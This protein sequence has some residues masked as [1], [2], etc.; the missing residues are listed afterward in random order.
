MKQ[1]LIEQLKKLSVEELKNL[2]NEVQQ[3]KTSVKRF[4]NGIVC[5]ICGKKH[6]QKFG[7]SSG[8]Q[9]YRCKDCGK[10]FTEY[11]KTVFFSTKKDYDTWF[12]YID[13]MMKG[14]SLAKIANKLNMSVLTAFH[15]RHKVLN[16]IRKQFEN[17]TISGVVE[18]DETFLLESHK[19]KKIEGIES[20]KRGGKAKLRGISHQQVGIM[21]AIDGNKNIIA[22]I[23]GKGRL[24]TNQI[25]NVLGNKIEKDS[26]L[27]TD[28]HK[29][30][31][32]FAKNHNLQ[33]KRIARG[34]YK[35]GIYHIN[36]VNNYHKG[37]KDFI[38]PFN[39]I[40]TRYLTNYLNWF[41]WIKS[42]ADN[43]LLIKDCLFGF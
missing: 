35:N 21:V 32:G 4:E 3:T 40:S 11:T 17:I 24:K 29:S 41:S 34:K 42:G 36:N 26:I 9:R 1:D 18:A 37:L 14:L 38:R 23:Y 43:N 31:I 12:K 15:W 27:V 6:I 8:I 5:P 30:Y 10:T 33:H 2:L 28:S 22:D 20:R 25:E 7:N 13:L 39:G 16:A 19:G